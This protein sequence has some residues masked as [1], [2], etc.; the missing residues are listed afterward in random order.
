MTFNMPGR[1]WVDANES[2]G[3]A[4][5]I[6]CTDGRVA[7]KVRAV[8]AA[9]GIVRGVYRTGPYVGEPTVWIIV[10]VIIAHDKEPT[11]RREINAITGTTIHN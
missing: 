6:T 9:H 2:G 10:N 7:A 1:W 8:L 5:K 4:L 11:I 3:S